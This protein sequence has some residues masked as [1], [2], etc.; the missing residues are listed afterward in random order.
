MVAVLR[1]VASVVRG[2]DQALTTIGCALFSGGHAVIEDRPGSGKT[3]MAKAFAA[4]VGGDFARVQATAC[5][6]YTS[7][8]PRD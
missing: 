7:P 4:T 6:L 1:A 8:S 3:T 5:L 2:Q